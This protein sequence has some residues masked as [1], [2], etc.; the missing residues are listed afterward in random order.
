MRRRQGDRRDG[1]R[2]AVKTVDGEY[3]EGEHTWDEG[4]LM[5]LHNLGL[6]TN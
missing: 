6:G 1:R 2:V 4:C 3:N 5:D